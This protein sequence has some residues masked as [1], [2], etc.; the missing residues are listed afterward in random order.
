MDDIEIRVRIRNLKP[1]EADQ[2]LKESSFDLHNV[3]LE[4]VSV[5]LQYTKAWFSALPKDM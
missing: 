1:E 5:W 4:R 3:T 2:L